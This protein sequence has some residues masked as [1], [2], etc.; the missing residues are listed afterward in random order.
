MRYEEKWK[1][2][3]RQIMERLK[4][5]NLSGV[6]EGSHSSSLQERAD[7]SVLAEEGLWR[8]FRETRSVNLEVP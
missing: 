4:E 1:V 2:N 6:A 8:G 5:E 7:G 3:G